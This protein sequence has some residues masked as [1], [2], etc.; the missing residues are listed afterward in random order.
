MK[1]KMS[2]IGTCKHGKSA[3]V[4]VLEQ[5]EASQGGTGRHRC[6]VCAYQVGYDDGKVGKK[7]HNSERC[8]HGNMAPIDVLQGLAES[9]AGTGRHKC[10]VC[11]YCE[12]YNEGFK[13]IE[14][15]ILSSGALEETEPPAFS[16]K[17][18]KRG[19][20]TFKGQKRD[21]LNEEKRK[22]ALGIAGELLVLKYEKKCLTEK[23]CHDLAEKV[24]HVSVE[25]GDGAGYDIKS[26]T[27]RGEEKYIEVKT[28]TSKSKS[29]PFLI[30]ENELEFARRYTNNYYIYRVYDLN[31]TK[32]SVKF[33]KVQGN[34][35][36]KFNISPTEYRVFP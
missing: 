28:T 17:N 12:G 4:A 1:K 16:Q 5:L 3:P 21:Y 11:A 10:T 36:E 20:Y 35:E 22:Q 18:K 8:N 2:S 7:K 13:G 32:K 25:E 6:V 34:P 14:R 29:M 30:S 15:P 23:G 31:R 9:Q 27:E 24:V 33:Y 19:S 26:F